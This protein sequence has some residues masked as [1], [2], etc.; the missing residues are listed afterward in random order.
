VIGL[1][2]RRM[3]WLPILAALTIA[4]GCTG[5]PAATQQ[6]PNQTPGQPTPGQGTPGQPTPGGQTPG[7]IDYNTTY[8]RSGTTDD[9]LDISQF[10]GDKP[11][12]VALADGFGGNSWRKITRAEYEDEAAK[13]DNITEIA[14]TDGQNDPQKAISDLNGLVAQGFNVIIGFADAGEAMAPSY[15]DA[16]EAGVSIV[17]YI[18][19]PGA[20]EPG[21]DVTDVVREDVAE[22][23]RVLAEWTINAMGGEGNLVMLGGTPGNGYSQAVYEAVKAAA[24]NY[25]DVN[26][27][28]MELGDTYIITNWEP[29]KTQEVVAGLLTQFPSIDGIVSDYGGGSVGGIRAF[30]AASRPIPPWS[31]ND[32]N[33][34]ACLWVNRDPSETKYQIATISSRN[35]IS[36][37]ALRR[38]VAVYQGIQNPEPQIIV[39][40]LSEDSLSDDPA[41]APKCE[42]DLPP[43]AILSSQ[44]TTDQLKALF[45]D[46]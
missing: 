26:L 30:Q 16:Y 34:F 41:L 6:P 45:G 36:R 37:V 7:G 42:E 18:A 25:P 10:C 29:G 1:L 11:M 39:L 3:R 35:W 20:A 9:L 23:G 31:A 21:K 32:S 27:L 13:C 43:D 40:P 5:G 4:V 33:E 15:R 2:G 38:A 14:Y 24:A 8:N 28:N 44:L 12:K 22:Y 46:Q 17:P 19:P